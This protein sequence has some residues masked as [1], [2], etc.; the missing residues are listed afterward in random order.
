MRLRK[1]LGV[2]IAIMIGVI[3]CDGGRVNTLVFPDVGDGR[4]L[5]VTPTR[6]SEDVTGSEVE[7]VQYPE[8]AIIIVTVGDSLTYG[9]RSPAGGYPAILQS[10]FDQADYNTIVVNKGIPGLTA[11]E[12]DEDFLETIAG[13][14]IVLLMIGINDIANPGGCPIPYECDTLDHTKMMLDKA[15][16]SKVTPLISTV[17]PAHSDGVFAWANIYISSHNGMIYQIA[18]EKEVVVVDNHAAIW[19]NGGDSL[20]E[21]EKVHFTDQ[22]YEIIA[23]QWYDALVANGLLQEEE[24]E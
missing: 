17:T 16:I 12:A 14:D 15:L 8:D 21:D 5:Q 7:S 6:P 22:G 4:N 20:Y 1:V 9:V 13:A 23:Q 2:C 3:G 18:A 24:E 11:S 19:L 10:K